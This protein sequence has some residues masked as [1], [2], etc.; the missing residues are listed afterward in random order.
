MSRRSVAV[1]ALVL[2]AGCRVPEHEAIIKPLPEGQSF[3]YQDLLIRGRAQAMAAV[4]AFYVDAWP[5]VEDAAAALEQ[6][7][8]FLPKTTQIPATV[9]DKV[10]PET[11]QLHQDAMK[12]GDAARAKNARAVNEALQRINLRIRELHAQDKA[13]P[14]IPPKADPGK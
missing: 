10:G 8:R 2:V 11:E 13:P 7:A 3:T 9:K 4:E 14:P 12:L 1:L 5:D 6:T